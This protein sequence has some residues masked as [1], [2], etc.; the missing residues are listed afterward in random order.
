MNTRNK[1]FTLVEVAIAVTIITTVLF[2]IYGVF[3]S[4]STAK[5]KLERQGEGYHRA[6][7]LFDRIG[8]EIRGAYILPSNPATRLI[9]G[10]NE[11]GM[12][13]LEFSTTATAPVGG[14]RV[15]LALV[16][17]ELQDDPATDDDGK[18]LMRTETPLIGAAEGTAT[19][20]RMA[21]DIEDMLFRYRE[22]GTWRE[23]WQNGLPQMVE[24]SLTLRVGDEKTPFLSAFEIPSIQAP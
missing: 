6:R 18:V 20:Y 16:R 4:V 17:Y 1:G 21:T 24:L 9:G 5:E 13:F 19:G 15:G 8:R 14:K 7:V 10:I 12:P 22:N 23:E 2:A 11:E 3:S